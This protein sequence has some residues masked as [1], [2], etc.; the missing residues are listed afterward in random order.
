MNTWPDGVGRL[1][2]AETDST[3]AEAVRRAQSGEPGPLWVMAQRQAKGRA[4]CG[5]RWQGGTGNLTASLL[6]RPQITAE[7]AALMSF[8]AALAAAD[9]MA[10]IAPGAK[11]TLKWPNDALVNGRKACGILLESGA[12]AGGRLGWLVIGVGVNLASHPPAETLPA[13]AVTPT[14]LVAEGGTPTAPEP[15]LDLLAAAM[16]TWS[17]R[18]RIEGFAPIR[19]AWL[20]RAARLGQSVTASFSTGRITGVFADV[21][22]SGALVLNTPDGLRRIAAADIHFPEGV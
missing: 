19:E 11:I 7:T 9:T 1:I 20:S 3:N 12:K 8:V 4:R 6:V 22:A 15:A 5:R 10:R 17:D 2:L 13:D 16:A 14:D 21:D 18:F